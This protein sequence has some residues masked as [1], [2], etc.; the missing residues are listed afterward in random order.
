[1]KPTL[2]IST[3]FLTV[4]ASPAFA[5]TGHTEAS[6]LISG[7]MHPVIGLDHILAMIAVGLL[8]TQMRGKSRTVLPAIFIAMMIAGAALASSA[9]AIPFI[10]QGIL[11]SVIILGAVIAGGYRLPASIAASLVGF[12]ALFHGAA[13]F[14]EMPANATTMA[15]GTGFLVA[16]LALI[17]G[18]SVLGLAAPKFL[19][20][21]APTTVRLA[22]A[23]VSFAGLGL[24]IA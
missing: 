13:H 4:A 17:A 11:G 12:F 22:G 18:G 2:F 19:G 24:A 5:H 8:A 3:A 21:V 14:V 1:M 20:K 10:E 23:A 9:I 15:Y 6:S 16:S 7:L